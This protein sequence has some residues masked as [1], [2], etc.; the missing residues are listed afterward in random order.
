MGKDPVWSIASNLLGSALNCRQDSPTHGLIEP[1]QPMSLDD[2][3]QAL[4][5]T[6]PFW[7]KVS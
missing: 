5:T 2:L 7:T 1:A 3:Q 6:K 4:E